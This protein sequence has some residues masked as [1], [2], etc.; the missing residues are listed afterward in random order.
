MDTFIHVTELASALGLGLLVG[1]ERERKKGEG[2]DRRFAGLRTFTLTALLG[3]VSMLLGG[4]TLLAAMTLAVAL[5]ASTAYIK[6]RGQDPGVTTGV[7]LLLVLL[8][9][10][11]C[12]SEAPLAVALAVILTLFLNYRQSLHRFA[13]NQLSE[14]EI[15]DGLT[16]ATAALVIMPLVPNEYIGPYQAVN[17]RSICLF[18]VLIMAMGALGHIAVRV[19]GVR[20]GLTV[21]AVA[22]GFVSGTATIATLGG[23]VRQQAEIARPAANAAIL[24]N[25][26]TLIQLSVILAAI[27]PA[28][29]SRL[30]L[31]LLMT[32]LVILLFALAPMI[33]ESG[34][35][36]GTLKIGHAFNLKMALLVALGISALFFM[37]SLMR[38][39]FGVSGLYVASLLGGLADVHAASASVAAQVKSGQLAA[40][41]AS[42]PILL[43]FSTNTLSKCVLA[44]SSG[45]MRFA[46][47][48]IPAQ[49]LILLSLWVGTWLQDWLLP[50]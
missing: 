30:W 48:V 37:T 18:T 32:T 45:G 27:S 49:I 36:E 7:A 38:V 13:L 6:R 9:G 8:L 23:R 24:S 40:V 47:R 5:L 43:A 39:W 22:T 46:R 1:L 15:R 25:L 20:Y 33:R 2:A 10:G 17:P 21:T 26:A 28:A 4:V 11:L 31:A 29:L 19:L 16:L 3:Y 42:L 12:N 34:T 50:G 44:W 41:G 14:T 35:I